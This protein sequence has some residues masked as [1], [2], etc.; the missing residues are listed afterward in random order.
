MRNKEGYQEIADRIYA[1]I[2]Q[3]SLVGMLFE[4]GETPAVIKSSGIGLL[5]HLP[6]TWEVT[7]NDFIKAEELSWQSILV[8]NIIRRWI[9]KIDEG[10]RQQ[11]IETVYKI[12]VPSDA[13]SVGDLTVDW[14]NTTVNIISTVKNMD[15]QTKRLMRK[16]TGELFKSAGKEIQKRLKK[17]SAQSKEPV[18]TQLK[19]TA[20]IEK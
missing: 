15:A 13:E 6:S 17:P 1:F 11:F 4:H 8:D 7:Y 5:Q 16:I 14:Q 12:L 20:K 19:L 10:Q 18:F 2:P 9:D 3:F